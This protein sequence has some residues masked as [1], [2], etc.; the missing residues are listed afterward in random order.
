MTVAI[1][2]G[3][4]RFAKMIPWQV[5]AVIAVSIAL[6]SFG[7]YEHHQ[8]YE[9][10]VA[11]YE[12]KLLAERE[13]YAKQVREL[14]AKQQQIITKTVIEYRDRVQVVK[15][16]GDEIVRYVDRLVPMDSPLLAGGVRVIH[17]AA[18][19]GHMPDDPERAAAA[20]APVEAATLSTTVAENYT[21][22]RATAEQLVALQTIVNQLG[23]K[24]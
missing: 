9:Q 16:K 7:K 6:L 4:W 19:T 1:L 3:L 5:Y 8:G 18:A 11:A 15:E 20:A 12:A 21:T 22:C 23:E 24:P 2:R 10:A 17:D 14:Q 13:A